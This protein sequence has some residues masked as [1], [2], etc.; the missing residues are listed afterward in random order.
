MNQQQP[1]EQGVLG[2]QGLSGEQGAPA[3]QGREDAAGT[4]WQEQRETV[5]G[6]WE[7]ALGHQGFGD[8][9]SFFTVGGHSLLAARV[10]AR[11]NRAAPARITVRD[12]FNHPTVGGLADLLATRA[13]AAA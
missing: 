10:V 4:L 12:L 3:A 5:R 8:D 11:I 9:E 6:V 13:S 7:Q 1:G 2:E